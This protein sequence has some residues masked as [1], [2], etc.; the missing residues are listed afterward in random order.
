VE[1]ISKDISINNIRIQRLEDTHSNGCY[2]V[3]WRALSLG[4]TFLAIFFIVLL[5]IFVW[6]DYS[7][8]EQ[9]IILTRESYDA[10]C[11]TKALTKITI[12]SCSGWQEEIL[13]HSVATSFA[14]GVQKFLQVT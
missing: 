11:I 14:N 13:R 10:I 3:V 5:S 2:G 12:N 6:E 4:A 8:Q 1:Q 7:Y 9:K